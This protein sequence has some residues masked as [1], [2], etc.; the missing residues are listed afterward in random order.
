MNVHRYLLRSFDYQ[1]I[2]HPPLPHITI[3]K[4]IFLLQLYLLPNCELLYLMELAIITF[5]L[6]IEKPNFN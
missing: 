2:L 1:R 3:C 4:S 6:L 5:L